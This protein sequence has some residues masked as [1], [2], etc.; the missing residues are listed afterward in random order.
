MD[1]K[2][3]ITGADLFDTEDFTFVEHREK[4]KQAETSFLSRLA[5]IVDK[6]LRDQE[7]DR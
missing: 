5:E 1:L 3:L 4:Q 6:Y 2:D 7:S